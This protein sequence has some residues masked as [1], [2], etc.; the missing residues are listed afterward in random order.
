LKPP[1]FSVAAIQPA[2]GSARCGDDGD[3]PL[4]AMPHCPRVE[5]RQAQGHAVISES[6]FPAARPEVSSSDNSFV[7]AEVT[8]KT[9]VLSLRA[10]PA[11]EIPLQKTMVDYSF[12]RPLYPAIPPHEGTDSLGRSQGGQPSKRTPMCSERNA[13]IGALDFVVDIRITRNAR[14]ISVMPLLIGAVDRAVCSK[15]ANSTDRPELASR[16]AIHA[17]PPALHTVRRLLGYQ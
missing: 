9:T 1:G 6:Q 12:S 5:P 11:C 4:S 3:D 14:S 15:I 13:R 16:R 7:G 10:P 17:L 2:L 8:K